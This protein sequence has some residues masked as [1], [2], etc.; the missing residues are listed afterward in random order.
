MP[1]FVIVAVAVSVVGLA[2]LQMSKKR[3]TY[4]LPGLLDCNVGNL[5]YLG[6]T[7]NPTWPMCSTK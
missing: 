7:D 6:M 5:A 1:F 2:V 4:T 3:K